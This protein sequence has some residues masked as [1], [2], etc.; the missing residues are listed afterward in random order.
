MIGDISYPFTGRPLTA[1]EGG[2]YLV[3]FLDLPGGM[4]DGGAA[5]PA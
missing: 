1:D 5:R 3:E 2:G 4:A